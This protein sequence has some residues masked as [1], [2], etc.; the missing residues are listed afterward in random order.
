MEPKFVWSD[1]AAKR[2]DRRQ[3]LASKDVVDPPRWMLSARDL[4]G[5]M[6][7]F[8]PFDAFAWSGMRLPAR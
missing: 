2:V 6:A 7:H 1:V 5:G 4:D 3:R 8:A